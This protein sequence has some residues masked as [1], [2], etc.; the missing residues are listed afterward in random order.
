MSGQVGAPRWILLLLLLC[1]ISEGLSAVL[2]LT[3]ATTLRT[4]PISYAVTIRIAFSG[5][6][7]AVLSFLLVDLMRWRRWAFRWM[8]SILTAYL[9]FGLLWTIV[10]VRADFE[11]G[12][13]GFAVLLA[14]MILIPIWW[15]TIRRR[16]LSK[17]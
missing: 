9:L 3:N 12:R 1:I 5:G 15:V 7:L 13:F 14:V 11:R 6:W 17:V 16:W 4:L 8:S 10:T 2:V